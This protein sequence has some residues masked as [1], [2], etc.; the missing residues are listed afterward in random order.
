ML[1]VIVFR[2]LR[3]RGNRYRMPGL[4][5]LQPGST[6]E[7]PV[8]KFTVG[9]SGVDGPR[10]SL[11]PIFCA[12]YNRPPLPAAVACRRRSRTAGGLRPVPRDM[13]GDIVDPQSRSEASSGTRF[14]SRLL[15]HTA[16]VLAA[17]RHSVDGGRRAADAAVDAGV[18]GCAAAAAAPAAAAAAAAGRGTASRSSKSNPAAAPIEAPKEIKPEPSRHQLRARRTA[19]VEGGV[20]GG[21]VGGIAG[22]C[23]NRRRHRRH[24]RRRCASAATSSRR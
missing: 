12:S 3:L 18:R 20:I 15:V 21:V 10:R 17:D 4:C 9:R 8:S 22:G 5:P 7:E 11:T 19:G 23:P 6:L 14:R 1:R 24:R 2:L 13:F 16:A